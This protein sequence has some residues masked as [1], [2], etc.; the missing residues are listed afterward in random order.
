VPTR[1]GTGVL[2]LAV[3]VFLLATN[4]MSGL[5]YVLDALL[6]SLLVVG[7]ATSLRPLRGLRATR[8]APARGVEGE[9]LRLGVALLPAHGGRFLIVE[10]GW[11]GSRARTLVPAAPRETATAAS[12]QVTPARRG[13]WAFA[14]LEILSRGPLGLVAA[15]RR[16]ALP[17]QITV[18]PRARPVPPQAL[19]HLAPVL[20]ASAAARRTR[21]REDLYGMRDYQP[22]DEIRRIHWRSSARRGALVV[23]E[24]ERPVDAAVTLVVDLDR[25][26]APA[27]LDAGVRAAASILRVARERRVDV[28][29]MGW[30]G[31]RPVEYRKW[32]EAMDW[33]AGVSPS[34]PPLAEALAAAAR[35]DRRVVAV[36]SGAVVDPHPDV[37]YVV[38]A[39]EVAPG[40][41][42]PGGLTYDADGTVRAW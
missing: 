24:F 40:A 16:F 22:G 29:V 36:A 4:L 25:R 8:D 30:D 41:A 2:F 21:Q 14:P 42:A 11:A 39:D 38:P 34:G 9:P 5:L 1:E 33:L 18:W 31:G 7:A 28:A 23:R 10:D 26:Q 15:R 12:V 27:R 3:A 37:T 35:P 32:E 13:R 19:E 17:G 20:D 6:V